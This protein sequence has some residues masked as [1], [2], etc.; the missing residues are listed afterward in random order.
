M[1]ILSALLYALSF[2]LSEYFWWLIFTYPIPLFYSIRSV[3]FSFI[4]GYIWG[5]AVFAL[6][7]SGFI[8]IMACMAHEYWVIGILLGAVMILYQALFPAFLFWF[9]AQYNVSPVVRLCLW[10]VILWLF[11]VWVDW[12]SMWIFGIQEGY[13]LMHPLIPLAQQPALLWLLPILGKQCLTILFLLVP[14]S[15]VLMLW[16]KNYITVLFF[17]CAFVPWLFSL[18]VGQSELQNLH[19]HSTIKSLP[20][21]ACS[22]AKNPV[23]TIK[24]VANQL[25]KII[26][27]NPAINI[28]IM[29]ESAFNVSNFADFPELLQLWNSDS[30][31][32][33]VHILFGASRW[34]GGNY[35]NSLH[36]VYDGALQCYHDKR[37]AMLVSERL[38][39]LNVALINQIYFNQ[40]AVVTISSC[41]R[42]SL[43]LLENVQFVPY[44]CSELF[45]N[46][47]PDDKY[48]G[49]PIIVI[50]NDALFMGSFWSLYIQQLLVLLAKVKA[51]QWQ[52]DIVYVSYV[53]SLFIDKQG[54]VKNING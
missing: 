39:W 48:Q 30:L 52:R 28:I 43:S 9:V 19:W 53:E 35:Y 49:V 2:F 44:I 26:A 23:V 41:Q 24:C 36:W 50:V 38:S 31:G 47:L 40:G 18:W 37:H 25:K 6:H 54:R 3:R 20:Y 45:C 22:V 42:R 13:S 15:V 12:Y 51:I 34:D 46:E 17:C 16:Y 5:C 27:Q 33:A 4:H 14:T 1:L 7:T 21:M 32:K 11:I 10:A 8:Y 29:P